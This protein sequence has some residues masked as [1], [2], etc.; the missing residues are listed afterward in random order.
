M[1]KITNDGLTRSGSGCLQSQL[2][3]YGNSEDVKGLKDD[4]CFT[5]TGKVGRRVWNGDQLSTER[6]QLYAADQA[7]VPR[8]SRTARHS[9][10]K[11]RA[12]RRRGTRR[13]GKTRWKSFFMNNDNGHV[14]WRLF[15]VHVVFWSRP[16]TRKERY[17]MS[18]KTTDRL[19]RSE[20]N[21]WIKAN[22]DIVVS[23]F[24]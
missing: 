14:C 2:Y 15:G 6:R 12:W 20:M 24:H 7:A 22:V 5:A 17:E 13:T 8:A 19:L 10:T 1:S 21:E 16:M 23:H 9:W 18:W 4:L 3:P 11:G